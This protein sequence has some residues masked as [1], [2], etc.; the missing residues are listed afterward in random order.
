[1]VNQME[2]EEQN[3]IANGIVTVAEKLTDNVAWF[4]CIGFAMYLIYVS[5]DVPEWLIAIIGMGA[6][7]YLKT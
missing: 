5:I 3:G 4:V 1:M 2:E 7:K 6:T